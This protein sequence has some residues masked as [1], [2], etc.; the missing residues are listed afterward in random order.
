MLNCFKVSQPEF[1]ELIEDI[2]RRISELGGNVFPKLNWSAPKDASWVN[3]NTLKCSGPGQVCFCLVL[4]FLCSKVKSRL[5][6]LLIYD[7]CFL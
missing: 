4:K 3:N 1:P 2:K 7:R 5:T 6:A